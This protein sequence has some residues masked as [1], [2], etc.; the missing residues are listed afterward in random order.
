MRMRSIAS[1]VLSRP[2]STIIGIGEHCHGDLL[3]WTVRLE[4]ARA[5]VRRAGKKL[6][7]LTENIDFFVAELR[8]K[9]PR[10]RRGDEGE[11]YPFLVHLSNRLPLHMDA[12]LELSR[13]AEGR[14]Y[15]VDVQALHHPDLPGGRYV[16]SK[17]RGM[18]APH[19]DG[20]LRNRQNAEM[21]LRIARDFT[22]RDPETVVMYLAHNEHVALGC[23]AC[24]RTYT[25]EG[26]LLRR[27]HGDGYMSIATYAR[28]IG[29]FWNNEREWRIRKERSR[30]APPAR[31]LSS[32]RTLLQSSPVYT[33]GGDYT[34]ANFDYTVATDTA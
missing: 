21:I 1:A 14:I 7:V 23:S 32:P 10:F 28:N 9:A 27:A 6:V 8:R 20:A 25:T 17:L 4:V 5:L 18:T 11:F 16:R 13:L 22:Q 15:G 31:V 19:G 24:N 34:T 29:S 30:N 33:L 26:A 2:S 12:A 3:S